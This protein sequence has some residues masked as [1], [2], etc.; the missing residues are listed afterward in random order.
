MDFVTYPNS[1]A[2]NG[3]IFQP[4]DNVVSAAASVPT[5]GRISLVEGSYPATGATVLGADGKS[6]GL[7]APVGTVTIGQ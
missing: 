6:Y 1:P 3:T 4:F 2:A 5:G 7:I